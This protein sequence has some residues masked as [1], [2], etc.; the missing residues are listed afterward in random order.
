M[1]F[2]LLPLSLAFYYSLPLSLYFLL[3]TTPFP[4]LSITS[5]LLFPFLISLLLLAFS[6]LFRIFFVSLPA[7]SL[8]SPSSS[9]SPLLLALSRL[10]VSLLALSQLSLSP[11][12]LS[13]SRSCLS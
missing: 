11:L 8:L 3:S 5:F 12:S 4:Y 9:R 6:R 13:L 7:L 2:S 10:L 1:F